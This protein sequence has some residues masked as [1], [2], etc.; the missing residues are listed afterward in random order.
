[1]AT[2]ASDPS[3]GP[4]LLP[5]TG[6]VSVE[7]LDIV[8]DDSMARSRE[9]NGATELSS[10]L[11]RNPLLRH[12]EF[13]KLLEARL[14]EYAATPKLQQPLVTLDLL[15]IWRSKSP[16]G[17]FL[18]FDSQKRVWNDVG[19][20]KALGQ[21]SKA[22]KILVKEFR[23]SSTSSSM[24]RPS[25]ES[26]GDSREQYSSRNIRLSISQQ[27]SIGAATGSSSLSTS[28]VEKHD[29]NNR[30]GI[31]DG[32]IPS[33][34]KRSMLDQT[35]RTISS[36][37]RQK[38]GNQR[39][40]SRSADHE[41][42]VQLYQQSISRPINDGPLETSNQSTAE[43]KVLIISGTPG[44]GKTSL[45]FS[46]E[47][48]V[49]S[50][51][52]FFVRSKFSEVRPQQEPLARYKSILQ[53]IVRI[54]LDRKNNPKLQE[55]VCRKIVSAAG[56]EMELLTNVVP[57]MHQVEQLVEAA[58]QSDPESYSKDHRPPRNFSLESPKSLIRMHPDQAFTPRMTHAG[59][60]FP[61]EQATAVPGHGKSS[62][63]STEIVG[64]KALS[65][66][67]FVYAFQKVLKAV[68]SPEHPLVILLDDFHASDSAKTHNVKDQAV[69]LASSAR[70]SGGLFFI[71]TYRLDP[72]HLS[73]STEGLNELLQEPLPNIRQHHLQLVG[74]AQDAL[75]ELLVDA[76]SLEASKL[77]VLTRTVSDLTQGNVL[78]VLEILR[79]FQ[80]DDL[81]RYDESQHQWV[82]DDHLIRQHPI[83]QVSSLRDLY[84][85][86]ILDM[87]SKFQE[88]LKACACLGP[89]FR[90][91]V[92]KQAVEDADAVDT[93][94]Q[95]AQDRG[96]LSTYDSQGFEYY[97]FCHDSMHQAAYH[98][99]PHD[100]RESWHLKIGQTLWNK[101]VHDEKLLE[102]F[103]FVIMEQ[104]FAGE[105]LIK[106][107]QD[108]INVASLCLHAGESMAKTSAFEMSAIYSL[109]G[110]GLLSRTKWRKQNTYDL[111]LALFNNAIDTCY[112]TGRIDRVPELVKEVRENA[113]V[114]EDEIRARIIL[115]YTLGTRQDLAS[116][117][118]LGV[119]TL[120]RLGEKLSR[121]PSNLQV[122]LE[123]AKTRRLLRYRSD[124][125]LQ[126][127]PALTDERLISIQLVLNVMWL[128][129][130]YSQPGLAA[131]ISC[132]MVQLSVDHGVS[133]VSCV[134]FAMFGTII[135]R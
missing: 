65:V 135:L 83:L 111:C 125:L 54:I 90:Y 7:L 28:F 23:Q 20:K 119:E 126:R 129:A 32:L 31:Q 95:T 13:R 132:R 81:L 39:L 84:R 100:K 124:T 80:D 77:E 35:K 52:G 74:L 49:V 50:H 107:M 22:L 89:E 60:E 25:S 86:K 97:F 110:I 109:K 18:K 68:S 120:A 102:S 114:F 45:A 27:G 43:T 9:E 59:G 12:G 106:D 73:E 104:L 122:W 24:S 72:D 46:L 19:D 94:V 2:I 14:D 17:R 118:E 6:I 99:I 76:L 123:M 30:V 69:E 34:P 36:F 96:F 63:S 112:A 116:A 1:M 44:V 130:Y 108:R 56:E 47:S 113:R 51:N 66:R 87:P 70:S 41:L 128:S 29:L 71:I 4:P 15:E 5:R 10:F 64:T 115:I 93:T 42:L 121:Y 57:F 98:L 127:L 134:G 131:M 105:S 62:V 48:R 37:I 101:A 67:R 88:V 21:I 11:P 133:N 26:E 33:P 55:M 38:R 61:G 103:L 78:F 16:G 79:A 53:D 8:L 91:D 82:C 75:Q 85:V 58:N 117:L 3:C 92:L 40:Y